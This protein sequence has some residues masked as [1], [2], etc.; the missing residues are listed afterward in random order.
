VLAIPVVDPS[1]PD[2]RVGAMRADTD[3]R[4]AFAAAGMVAGKYELMG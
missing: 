1:R 3:A 4:G 2:A